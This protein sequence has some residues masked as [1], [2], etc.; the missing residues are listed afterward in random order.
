MPVLVSGIFLAGGGNFKA[1]VS[2]GLLVLPERGTGGI[3]EWGS[4][5]TLK[6]LA[7]GEAPCSFFMYLPTETPTMANAVNA[8]T[9]ITTSEDFR[10]W[11]A[12][13]GR[14]V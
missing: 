12:L 8:T 4:L 11:E 3:R 14:G 5:V 7:A 9:A 13:R 6:V 10:T 2:V 1:L